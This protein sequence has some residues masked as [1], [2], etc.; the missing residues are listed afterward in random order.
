MK[1]KQMN[2]SQIKELVK[3]IRKYFNRCANLIDIAMEKLIYDEGKNTKNISKMI[4]TTKTDS[5]SLLNKK[6]NTKGETNEIL[7]I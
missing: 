3:T 7:R 2:K 4:V 1:M 5:T 6:H